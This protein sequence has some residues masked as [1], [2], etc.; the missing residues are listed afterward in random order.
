MV[1]DCGR[2]LGIPVYRKGRIVQKQ[3]LVQVNLRRPGAMSKRDQWEAL[4]HGWSADQG[5]HNKWKGR[6]REE[7]AWK[8]H[9][10]YH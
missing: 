6:N 1:Y 3:F 4:T 10:Q 5:C 9:I 8:G 2:T 7:G